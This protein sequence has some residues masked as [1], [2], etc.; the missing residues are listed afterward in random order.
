MS[1]VDITGRRWNFVV[2]T[3][4][5]YAYNHNKD[6]KG[7]NF[8]GKKLSRFLTKPAKVYF[9]KKK[10]KIGKSAKVYSREN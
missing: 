9:A 5:Y 2:Q 4:Y 10:I 3:E 7:R 6:F 1:F 8:R